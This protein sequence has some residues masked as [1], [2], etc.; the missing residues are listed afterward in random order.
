MQRYERD[1]QVWLVNNRDY[2]RHNGTPCTQLDL[3]GDFDSFVSPDTVV[4]DCER[5]GGGWVRYWLTSTNEESQRN[6]T[7][8]VEAIEAHAAYNAAK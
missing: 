2:V 4:L 6:T 8:L 5:L 7:E 1:G 3:H